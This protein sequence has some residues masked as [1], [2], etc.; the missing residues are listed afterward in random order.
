MPVHRLPL[1]EPSERE[2]Q[3]RRALRVRAGVHLR[4][5]LRLLEQVAAGPN[6]GAPPWRASVYGHS[7][8]MRLGPR[9]NTSS[10]AS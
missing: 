6:G 8:G 10:T 2:L 9:G 1:R 5:R 4:Y 3:L 7:L